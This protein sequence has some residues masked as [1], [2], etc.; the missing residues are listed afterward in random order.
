MSFK[1]EIGELVDVDQLAQQL[2]ERL[3]IQ[4]NVDAQRIAERL[5]GPL[6]QQVIDVVDHH[7]GLVRRGFADLVDQAAT[8]QAIRCNAGYQRPG[9]QEPWEQLQPV[10]GCDREAEH[11]GPHFHAESGGSWGMPLHTPG[12]ELADPNGHQEPAAIAA[13]VVPAQPAWPEGGSWHYDR[14]PDPGQTAVIPRQSDEH[15][16]TG[17]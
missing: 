13:A 10:Y 17:G 4:V 8:R 15:P 6:T 7:M 9:A 11:I 2:N 12:A 5:Y 1:I 16:P 3:K 14:E